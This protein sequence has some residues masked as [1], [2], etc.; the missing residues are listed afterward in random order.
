M[1]QEYG[2]N[3]LKY[4]AG[5]I[6]R[7]E[8][9]YARGKYNTENKKYYLYTNAAYFTML[10]YFYPGRLSSLVMYITNEGVLLDTYSLSVNFGVRPVINLKSTV[11]YVSGVGSEQDPYVVKPAT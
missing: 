2:N 6:R 8:I 7:D 10:Y 4:P 3:I 9:A 11:Q 1:P 5:L